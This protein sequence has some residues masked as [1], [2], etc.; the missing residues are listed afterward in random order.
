MVA[1]TLIPAGRINHILIR[2]WRIQYVK[3]WDVKG[4]QITLAKIITRTRKVYKTYIGGKAGMESL[5]YMSF[6]TVSIG[7]N[8]NY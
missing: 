4:Y 3:N 1:K 7:Q 6:L 8:L 5:M 2:N